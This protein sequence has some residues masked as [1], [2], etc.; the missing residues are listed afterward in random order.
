MDCE[1]Q[2]R[3]REPVYPTMQLLFGFAVCDRIC[4]RGHLRAHIFQEDHAC[5]GRYY[6]N[7]YNIIT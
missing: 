5:A 7:H 4:R 6:Y 1:L 3:R 2:P